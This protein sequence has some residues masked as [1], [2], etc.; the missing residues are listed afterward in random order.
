MSPLP[1][2]PQLATLGEGPASL[3][4][5]EAELG[6]KWR[7]VVRAGVTSRTGNMGWAWEDCLAWRVG[8]GTTCIKVERTEGSG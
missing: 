5:E 7:C 2:G 4:E 8:F 3:E 6:W 1:G